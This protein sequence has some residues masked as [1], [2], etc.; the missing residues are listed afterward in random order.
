M[1][2][3]IPPK[4]LGTLDHIMRVM[5]G[6]DALSRLADPENRKPYGAYHYIYD[7]IKEIE[8]ASR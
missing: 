2:L 5:E 1:A 6:Q 7:P 4:L 3:S 8:N